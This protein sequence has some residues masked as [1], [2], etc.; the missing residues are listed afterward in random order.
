[1][2]VKGNLED[3]TGEFSLLLLQTSSKWQIKCLL[4]AL[5]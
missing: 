3:F 5:S 2:D 1:M 4:V